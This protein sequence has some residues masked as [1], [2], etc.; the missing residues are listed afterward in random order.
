MFAIHNPES[1]DEDDGNKASNHL[2][3]L[4]SEYTQGPVFND[5]G[6]EASII[7]IYSHYTQIAANIRDLKYVPPT[8]MAV[9]Y[10]KFNDPGNQVTSLQDAANSAEFITYKEDPAYRILS[11]HYNNRESAD[12]KISDYEFVNINVEGNNVDRISVYNDNVVFTF[13]GLGYTISNTGVLSCIHHP[14]VLLPTIRE[15]NQDT[16][17]TYPISR[18]IGKDVTIPVNVFFHKGEGVVGNARNLSAVEQMSGDDF[19]T[20]YPEYSTILDRLSMVLTYIPVQNA[21]GEYSETDY[22]VMPDIKLLIPETDIPADCK[23]I[24]KGRTK[25]E[26]A[27]FGV[28]CLRNAYLD[29]NGFFTEVDNDRF[30][31]GNGISMGGVGCSAA[32][33]ERDETKEGIDEVTVLN[34]AMKRVFEGDVPPVPKPPKPPADDSTT[35]PS[36]TTMETPASQEVQ[37]SVDYGHIPYIAFNLQRNANIPRRQIPDPDREGETMDDPND[38]NLPKESVAIKKMNNDA[39]LGAYVHFEL[40]YD[41]FEFL[42]FFLDKP[43][44]SL[45]SAT[46]KKG[47][48]FEIFRIGG[49]VIQS[50]STPNSVCEFPDDDQ[51]DSGLGYVTPYAGIENPTVTNNTILDTFT[52]YK[53]KNLFK[54]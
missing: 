7:A 27:W 33:F 47:Y 43:L 10:S 48:A 46:G 54:Q 39:Q 3:K 52:F 34:R 28:P 35:E 37:E 22:Y 17:K 11:R 20:R 31:S 9:Q 45:P 19:R 30:P 25:K 23:F 26:T 15:I 38:P 49:Q 6:Q 41:S 36:G 16:V 44:L 2:A 4:G 24:M 8:Y 18:F 21:E 51:G 32:L 5:R 50:Q 1:S 29:G 42:N 13:C 14:S 40:Q 53:R 12:F